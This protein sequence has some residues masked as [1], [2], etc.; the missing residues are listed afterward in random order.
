LIMGLIGLS[1]LCSLIVL[2]IFGACGFIFVYFY[3]S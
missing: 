3:L 1:G 2:C